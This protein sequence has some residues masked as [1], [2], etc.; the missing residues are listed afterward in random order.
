MRA[1]KQLGTPVDRTAS[2]IAANCGQPVS[3]VNSKAGNGHVRA[4]CAAKA[5]GDVSISLRYLS[6]VHINFMSENEG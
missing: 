4:L 3:V 6:L 2:Y 5:C 1:A